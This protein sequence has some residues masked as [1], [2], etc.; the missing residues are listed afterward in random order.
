[1]ALPA[2]CSIMSDLIRIVDLEVQAH[3]GV[4]DAER[5]QAQR[6]LISMEMSIES[7]T[8]AAATDDLTKTVNYYDV[9][10]YI[11][12]FTATHERKL[13]ETLAEQLASDLLK[14]FAIKKLTLEIKKFIL[15]D[16]RWVSV[17]ITRTIDRL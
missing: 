16:A 15:P 6:L 12:Q 4:P 13:L 7:F 10:Q 14:N 9:A 17:E 11:K 8:H 1:M 2:P 5:A 3:I